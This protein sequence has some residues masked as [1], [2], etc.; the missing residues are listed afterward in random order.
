MTHRQQPEA[1]ES[2][3]FLNLDAA[4]RLHAFILILMSMG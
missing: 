1:Q 3:A 2:E 4:A